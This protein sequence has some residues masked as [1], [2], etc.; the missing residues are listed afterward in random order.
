M[1]AATKRELSVHEIKRLFAQVKGNPRA[2]AMLCMIWD[3]GLT[4]GETAVL[5]W[6]EVDLENLW[7]RTAGREI[8]L[9]VRA[10]RALKGLERRGEYVFPS[11]ADAGA[12]MA[13]NSVN[14]IIRRALN[15]AGLAGVLP[16]D[17]RCQYLLRMTES[18]TLEE[19]ARMT[20]VQIVTLR[21]N[22]REY[23][24]EGLPELTP[25]GSLRADAKTLEQALEEEGDTVN[26]RIVRL[27]WQGGLQIR[28]IQKLRWEDV[29][30]SGERW[31]PPGR[32]E[33]E[34]PA[35]LQP[36][37][38]AWRS[39]G[40]TYVIEG[41]RAGGPLEL[42]ALSRRAANFFISYGLEG[43]SLMNLRGGGQVGTEE[44][45]ALL[46]LVQ[47]RGGCALEGARRKL[48]L[49]PNQAWGLAESL[50]REGLLDPKGGE[51]LYLPGMSG[52]RDQFYSALR[53]RRGRE[54]DT[55]SLSAVSGLKGGRLQ[56]YI[57]EAQEEGW[58]VKVRHGVYR[59]K[60]G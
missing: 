40:G 9:A 44:R 22:W 49:T 56:Y 35:G 17:L 26:S 52:P 20:G 3:E 50:R 14:R 15:G 32:E 4:V 13:R 21:D 8:P 7:L 55:L 2:E 28:E 10:A 29:S 19:A 25:A 27:S 46:A 24:R 45:T 16:R 59:V 18:H 43:L 38:R 41:P 11:E 33:E 48:G 5:R 23:G 47:K 58:L 53:A 1:P 12:P 57:K 31:T 30:A 42:A 37:L 60:K 6:A 54:I 34:V 36:H 39:Q 51:M